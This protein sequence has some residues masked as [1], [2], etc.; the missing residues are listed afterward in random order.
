[1]TRTNHKQDG[2]SILQRYLAVVS[3]I[4]AFAEGLAPEP[5]Q[6]DLDS[7]VYLGEEAMRVLRKAGL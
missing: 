2:T 4:D 3:R 1:M 7:L 5:S 6:E